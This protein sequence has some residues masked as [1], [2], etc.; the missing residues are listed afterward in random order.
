MQKCGAELQHPDLPQ[1]SPESLE[2]PPK[3]SS[4]LPWGLA[5]PDLIQLFLI[6]HKTVQI[7]QAA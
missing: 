3:L 7:I 4:V 5:Q 2:L 6:I 1:S